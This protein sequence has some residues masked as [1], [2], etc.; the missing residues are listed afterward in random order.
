MRSGQPYELACHCSSRSE[1]APNT[2]LPSPNC[3]SSA[4]FKGAF[5]NFRSKP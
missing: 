5:T 3:D 2:Y 4:P 1:G